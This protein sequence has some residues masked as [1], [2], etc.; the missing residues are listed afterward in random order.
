MGNL[1]VTHPGRFFHCL[2]T[3]LQGGIIS[4]YTSWK[5]VFFVVAGASLLTGVTAIFAIP[6]E[7]ARKEHPEDS[8]RASG[9]DW[10]GA[11]LFTSGTLLLLISLSEGVSQGWKSAFVIGILIT[12]V[13]FILAFIYWQHHLESKAVK[14]PLM[15]VS[16]FRNS[17]FTSAM[18]IVFLFSGGFTNFTVYSTY[19]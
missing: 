12:S 5:V 10:I 16:T 1:L 18:V 19:L 4:Q 9:V 6:K 11:F 3:R 2:L 13:V 15:P 14:E 17:R 7:P 8:P